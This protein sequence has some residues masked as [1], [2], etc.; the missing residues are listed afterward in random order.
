MLHDYAALNI[1]KE[2]L[3][4][5][6]TILRLSEVLGSRHLLIANDLSAQ[7]LASV[8]TRRLLLKAGTVD[9]SLSLPRK[10]ALARAT[11]MHQTKK[12][13]RWHFGMKLNIG[14]DANAGSVY[15]EATTAA[16]AH[17]VTRARSGC[18]GKK[19]TPLAM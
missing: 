6:K 3:S 15:N 1:G 12:G 5:E 7:N 16:T 4:D 14:I 18:V 13:K 17:E 19:S 8:S 11:P 2:C 10:T 9:E